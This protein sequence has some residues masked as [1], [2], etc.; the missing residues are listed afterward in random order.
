MAV[1]APGLPLIGGGKNK[2]Q[3]VYVGDVAS[4]VTASLLSNNAKG[5]IYEL[6][7]PDIMTFR[8]AMA[9]ILKQTKRRRMLVPVPH[10]VMSLAATAM[11]VFAKSPCHARSI[12]AS[13]NR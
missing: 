8:E 6:G 7:G 10:G 2:V 5:K 1:M 13:E 3:P 12:K 11:S 4:A 9:F